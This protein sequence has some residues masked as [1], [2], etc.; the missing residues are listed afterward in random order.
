MAG[1]FETR[2]SV[3][4][5]RF[6]RRKAASDYLDQVHGLHR[7]PATLAKL[8]VIGG[9][10]IFRRVGRVPLYSTA[11]LDHWVASKLSAPMRSTSDGASTKGS[12]ADLVRNRNAQRT[13]LVNRALARNAGGTDDPTN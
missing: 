7:A 12:T 10:P 1:H 2:G 4:N 9:G 8:A 5:C 6:L 13:E 11:D 3:M